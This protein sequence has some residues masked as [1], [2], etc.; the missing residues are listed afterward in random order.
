MRLYLLGRDY[1]PRMKRDLIKIEG[2]IIY[3]WECDLPVDRGR[4]S[5]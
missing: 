1:A 2:G 5:L 3:N 4:K